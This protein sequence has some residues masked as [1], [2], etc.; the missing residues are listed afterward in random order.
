MAVHTDCIVKRIYIF[1]DI[2]VCFFM[3][4]YLNL[5]SHSL[6]ISEWKDSMQALSYG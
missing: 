6:F 5:Q 2:S 3:I 1:K 4:L